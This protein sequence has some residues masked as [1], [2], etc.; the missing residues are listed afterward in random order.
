LGADLGFLPTVNFDRTGAVSS[1]YAAIVEIDLLYVSTLARKIDDPDARTF[2]EAVINR[3]SEFLVVAKRDD[4]FRN[5][6]GRILHPNLQLLESA[7]GATDIDAI[8][9]ASK[10]YLLATQ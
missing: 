7:I 8:M 9:I 6:D 4:H 5:F 10:I 1:A 2:A 3:R